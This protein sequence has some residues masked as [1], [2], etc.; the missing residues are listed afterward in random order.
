MLDHPCHCGQTVTPWSL[1]FLIG[2]RRAAVRLK[3]MIIPVGNW[4]M[5][6]MSCIS[7]CEVMS[8]SEGPAKVWEP[9]LRREGPGWTASLGTHGC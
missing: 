2:P 9:L 6:W 3:S 8:Y 7:L 4:Q 1:R 5:L